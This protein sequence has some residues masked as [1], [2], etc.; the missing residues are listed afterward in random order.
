MLT[1]D[2]VAQGCDTK[3]EEIVTFHYNHTQGRASLVMHQNPPPTLENTSI[4][5]RRRFRVMVTGV[6]MTRSAIIDLG[7]KMELHSV[8]LHYQH[9]LHTVTRHDD[10]ACIAISY[11][12]DAAQQLRAGSHTQQ[13][14]DPCS[15]GI[16][17][18]F[19]NLFRFIGPLPPPLSIIGP[20]R[21]GPNTLARYIRIQ[22]IYTPCIS[23]FQHPTAPHGRTAR[24]ASWQVVELIASSIPSL[25]EAPP[26][27]GATRTEA[28]A[29]PRAQAQSD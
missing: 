8:R 2:D 12:L 26:Q 14:Q 16:D 27:A 17:P 25:K 10:F 4:M 20:E 5:R 6:P 19:V 13:K 22:T 7:S 9:D 18:T 29:A 24:T 21:I 3:D 15:P 28:H 1:K 23:P 11:L